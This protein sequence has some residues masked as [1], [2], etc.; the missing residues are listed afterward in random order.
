[1]F[2]Y[3]FISHGNRA[4][5]APS[6]FFR[7]ICALFLIL[8]CI[9]LVSVIQS[10]DW[11]SFGIFPVALMVLLLLSLLYRDSWVFDNDNESATY[12]WGFGPFV[13]REVWKYS[14][15]E[16]IEVTHFIKGIPDTAEKQVPS[17][18]HRR[19]VVLSIRFDS[20]NKKD[21][22]IIGEKKSGGK[23]ER[24]ASWLSGFTGLALFVDSA[25]D[26]RI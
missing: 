14:D 7:L 13:K 2:S 15:I 17:W 10:D 4:I 9:G 20:D 21:L 26:T 22:E 5:Y 3:D 6:I 1:M 23:I 12:I 11:N 19:Q 16:R 8:L 25:G 18:K 24:N